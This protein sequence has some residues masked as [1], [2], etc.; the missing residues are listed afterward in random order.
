LASL[1]LLAFAAFAAAAAATAAAAA[2]SAF[3]AAA[4]LVV[5]PALALSPAA[6]GDG[7]VKEG[8]AV[9]RA[10][11]GTLSCCDSSPSRLPSLPP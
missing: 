3:A 9:A 11:A 5:L 2:F 10:Q 7:T 8:L 4:A 1:G 6:A